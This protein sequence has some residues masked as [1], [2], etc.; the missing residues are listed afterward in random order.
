M[1]QRILR[2]ED[3]RFLRGEGLY[4][5]NQEVPG[6]LHATFVR[7][8]VAHARI[9][10]IDTS[11]VAS[12]PG[13]QVFTAADV[14]L[15][16]FPPPPIP[17]INDK[18]VRPFFASDVVRFVGDIVAVVLTEDRAA[19]ADA[20]ELVLV[21]YDPLPAVVDPEA[22]LAGDVL[23]Y[24]ELG[25]NVCASHPLEAPDRAL[26]ESCD[27]VVSGRLVS[28]RLAACP[29]E[30]R[31]CVA[32]LGEDGRMT[33]WLSTQTPHLDR[34]VLGLFLGLG[35][36]GVR[37]VAPDVGGGFGAKGLS[38]E[39]VI[40]P[41]LAR[42]TGRPVRWTESRSE[43]MVAMQ[44]GRA[45]VLEFELGGSRDG[46]AQA[47]RLR[48]VQ[49]A[50]AYPGLGAILPG[51]TALMSSGVYAIPKIESDTVS[52]VT[53][54]T[55]TGPFRGA[56]RPEAAQAIERA[57]DLFAA[58][59]GLDPAEVRRRNLYPP[60]AFPLTTASGAGYDSGDY[61]RALDLAL[62]TAGYEAL[63]EEQQPPARVR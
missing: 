59:L 49:D 56:G 1:G 6:A 38:V 11:G 43:N 54:T 9:A 46:D 55:P 61:G 13:A 36:E 58:E 60:D 4:V 21:D 51:F 31:G 52:V 48:V 14:E 15:G 24:P 50:G 20:A 34:H 2:V 32:E 35:D 53:N 41:W 29:L 44:H 30:A 27:V 12:V 45:A 47:Y 37:V 23:L 39:T 63:R 7:S 22:G 19:G 28:Q 18:M 42:K 26:F 33:L 10:G 25:T 5:E 62:E 40:V 16:A 57:M 8:P 3:D 17:G